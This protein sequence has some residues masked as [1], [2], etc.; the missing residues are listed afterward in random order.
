MAPSSSLTYTYCTE[1]DVQTLLSVVGEETRL[2]DDISG[3]LSATESGYLTKIIAWAT[4]RCNLYLLTKYPAGDLAESWIVNDW[5]TIIATYIVCCR[6]GNPPAGAIKQMYEQTLEDLKAIKTG[7]LVLP[8][9]ALRQAAWPAWSNISFA[10]VYPLRKIRVQRQISE[11]RG[12][13][14]DYAQ[15][16]DWSSEYLAGPYA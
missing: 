7:E 13:T 3:S 8:D 10:D 9:T 1:A 12:G 15:A 14:P 5:C 4:S 2:D 11:K 16:I 6:R